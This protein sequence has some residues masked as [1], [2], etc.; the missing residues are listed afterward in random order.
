MLQPERFSSWA[1]PTRVTA[2][3]FR[4]INTCKQDDKMMLGELSS[5]EVMDVENYLMKMSQQ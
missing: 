4:F 2:W 5:G 1:R 3:T